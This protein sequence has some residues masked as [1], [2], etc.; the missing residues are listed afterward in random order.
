MRPFSSNL[1][2]TRCQPSQ[3]KSYCN[4]KQNG[5]RAR[6]EN[7]QPLEGQRVSLVND[8]QIPSSGQEGPM[9]D[10]GGEIQEV[11]IQVVDDASDINPLNRTNNQENERIMKLSELKVQHENQFS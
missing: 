6:L 4:T 5:N 8:W 10:N 2:V 1:S 3:K 11:H 9:V 7:D